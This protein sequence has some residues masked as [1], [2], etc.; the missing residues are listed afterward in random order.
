MN[1]GG[2]PATGL[3]V[4]VIDLADR[5]SCSADAAVALAARACQTHFVDGHTLLHELESRARHRLRHQLRLALWEVADGA[6]S[7]P[8]TWFEGRVR[9]PHGI[10]PFARQAKQPDRT[11][12]DLRSAE[13]RVN[14]EIDGRL[15][16]A[17]ER[18]H[19]DRRRDRRAAGRGEITLRVTPLE[20]DQTPCEVASD[21]ALALRQRGWTGRPHRCSPSCPVQAVS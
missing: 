9:A 17:G 4:T 6:E 11:R 1:A 14:V 13:F 15:W 21:L 16:H 18:F 20:L 10:P 7:L 5:Q 12:T 2:L 8:E 19:H 3:A